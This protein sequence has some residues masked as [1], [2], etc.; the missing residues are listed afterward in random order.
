MM[1]DKQLLFSEAQAITAAA[2]STNVIDL[3]V[4]RSIGVGE[5]LYIFIEVDVAFTDSSSDSTLTVNLVTDDNASLSS[6]ST[7]Q[8]LVTIPAL[9]A[10]GTQYIVRL[11]IGT[12]VPYERYI[13]LVYTPNNGNLTTGSITAGIVKD[14]QRNLPY[15]AS[16][17]SIS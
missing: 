16:G 13:G 6:D 15:Y 4:A 1:L 5:E 11:P 17:F 7:I 2:D 8:T 3:G 9:A 14:P 10:A 12:T